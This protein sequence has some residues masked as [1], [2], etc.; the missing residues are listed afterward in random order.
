[1]DFLVQLDIF[2]G[3]LD[4]LLYLVRRH[5]VE[6]AEIPIAPI[7]DQFLEYL[8]CSR[9]WMSTPLAIFSKSPAR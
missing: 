9:N 1:M 6:I 5:E 8:A 2:S 4:L 3:P 7:T